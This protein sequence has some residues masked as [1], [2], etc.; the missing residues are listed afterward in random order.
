MSGNG[1]GGSGG[2]GGGGALLLISLPTF[3]SLLFF[4][5]NFKVV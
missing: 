3:F 2:G 1:S 4:K 5:S